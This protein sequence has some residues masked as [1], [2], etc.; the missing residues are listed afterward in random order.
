MNPAAVVSRAYL[1]FVMN[2]FF[3]EKLNCSERPM[4]LFLTSSPVLNCFNMSNILLIAV[5]FLGTQVG[6]KFFPFKGVPWPAGWWG[7]PRLQQWQPFSLP[8]VR[9]NLMKWRERSSP[10][11]QTAHPWPS[12]SEFTACRATAWGTHH[13][14]PPGTTGRCPTSQVHG[15]QGRHARHPLPWVTWC[16]A[17]C[18]VPAGAAFPTWCHYLWHYHLGHPNPSWNAPQIPIA[19][20]KRELV[21]PKLLCLDPVREW[22]WYWSDL[23]ILLLLFSEILL[24]EAVISFPYYLLPSGPDLLLCSH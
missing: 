10:L 11:V 21:N 12:G 17:V 20:E 9:F 2:C 19:G 24:S 13:L 16:C 5:G 8:P 4:L 1:F 14:A 18:E 23:H 15:L 22:F 7:K 3:Q 6:A